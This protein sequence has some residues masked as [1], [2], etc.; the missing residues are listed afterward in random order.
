MSVDMFL[1]A[2]SGIIGAILGLTGGALANAF[3]RRMLQDIGVETLPKDPKKRY[4][5]IAQRCPY[6]HI[7]TRYDS[8]SVCLFIL[9]TLLLITGVIL[10][11]AGAENKTPIMI[12]ETALA[13]YVLLNALLFIIISVIL[14]VIR[15]IQLMNVLKYA[16]AYE[17]IDHLLKERRK[18]PAVFALPTKYFVVVGATIFI[19]LGCTP[20]VLHY[21]GVPW[22][23][24]LSVVYALFIS[25]YPILLLRKVQKEKM[26]S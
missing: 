7:W 4:A 13:P 8:Y 14:M 22:F 15:L 26:R 18:G 5:I 25:I 10:S 24:G 1:G 12:G 19:Y 3:T 23:I 17:D 2:I 11:F 9:G 21:L 16:D 20:P 6:I